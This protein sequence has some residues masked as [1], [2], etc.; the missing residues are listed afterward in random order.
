MN[1]RWLPVEGFS[2]Y[3]VSDLG[4]VQS[5]GRQVLNKGSG[6]SYWVTG[7]VLSQRNDADGYRLVDLYNGRE[8]VTLKVHRLVAAA[9]VANPNALPEVN[10]KDF[11]RGNNV[12]TNLQWSTHQDNVTHTVQ[13]GRNNPAS[14][15]RAIV[16][17]GPVD[18]LA[19]ESIRHAERAGFNRGAIHHCLA[20]RWSHHNNRIWSYA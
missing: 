12:F 16:A 14:R 1:E 7:R 8:K 19:F 18:T 11:V 20:G 3:A 17:V 6:H 15:W 5:V 9:F 10:H 2:L 13:A 4:R